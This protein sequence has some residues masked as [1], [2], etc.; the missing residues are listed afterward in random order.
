MTVSKR[1][2]I[3]SALALLRGCY[4]EGVADDFY[5]NGQFFRA[6]IRFLI[7]VL[8]SKTVVVTIFMEFV[9]R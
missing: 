5:T 4:R 8:Y 6:L 9:C 7:G 1:A 3:F 2:Q